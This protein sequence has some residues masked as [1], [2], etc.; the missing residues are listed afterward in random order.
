MRRKS[1]MQSFCKAAFLILFT[2]LLPVGMTAQNPIGGS[3]WKETKVTLRVSDEP[4]GFVLQ[5]VAKA[6]G[7]T[8]EL[9]DVAIVGINEPTTLNVTDMPLDKVLGRL[10]G[11]QIIR[12]RYEYG[13]QIVIEADKSQPAVQEVEKNSYIVNGQVI[14]GDTNE[15]AVGATIVITDGTSK[16]GGTMLVGCITDAD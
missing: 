13:R 8:L 15:P 10:I 1:K 11:N 6:A 5:K 2:L 14:T 16:T 4:L 9:Q 12:I 3:N 7:A